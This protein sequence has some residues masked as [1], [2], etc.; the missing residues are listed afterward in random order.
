MCHVSYFLRCLST[1]QRTFTQ[2]NG[3][4]IVEN[5]MVADGIVD[6]GLLSKSLF[7]AVV[8]PQAINLVANL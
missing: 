8:T 3:S 1:R 6:T 2:K 5:P 4:I 7:V